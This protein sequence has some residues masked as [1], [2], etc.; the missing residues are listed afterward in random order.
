MEPFDWVVLIGSLGAMV[1]SIVLLAVF[2]LGA[3]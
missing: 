3:L 1:A 2:R